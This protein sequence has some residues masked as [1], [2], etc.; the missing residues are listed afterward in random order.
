MQ[1]SRSN[2]Q[3]ALRE[4]IF[5]KY[6]LLISVFIWSAA[7]ADANSWG[8]VGE[9]VTMQPVP[10][11]L[12]AMDLKTEH[13]HDSIGVETP[14]PRLRWQLK[15]TARGQVQ[16]AYRI[17]AATSLDRLRGSIADKWDSGKVDSDNSLPG[18]H[19]KIPQPWPVKIPQWLDRTG[20]V[21]L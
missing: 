8:N 9:P 6:P 1:A 10:S 12:W 18:G 4:M 5:A 21:S 2:L 13:I 14:W 7:S 11:A 20:S 17:L 3:S 16:T 15:A 19:F